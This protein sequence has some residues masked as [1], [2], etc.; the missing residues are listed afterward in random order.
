MRNH[1]APEVYD[2]F[3]GSGTSLVA[4]QNLG[5]NVYAVE[6]SP[7]YCAVILER[8]TTAFPAIDIRKAD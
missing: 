8:M 1:V 2:P 3:C 6:I 5:R 7:A 4:G